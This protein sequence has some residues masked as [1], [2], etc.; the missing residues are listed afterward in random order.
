M[1]KTT[2]ILLLSSLFCRTAQASSNVWNNVSTT[3]TISYATRYMLYGY[4]NGPDLFHADIYLSLP[5]T[6]RITLWGGSWYGTQPNGN[7]N[8]IDL[9]AGVDCQLTDHLSAGVAYSIFNYLE[10]PFET[11]AEAH[12]LSGHL[13]LSAGDFTVSL[14][15]L[16][17]SEANG[18]L[19]RVTAGYYH[20]LND[21]TAVQLDAEY[22]YSFGYFTAEDGPN[23]ALLKLTIPIQLNDRFS[24]RPF[25]A[26]SIALD[27][28]DAFAEDR[29]YGGISLSMSL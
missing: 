4:D 8:E 28:I 23:H 17:D 27:R 10:V 26:H 19:T 14:R 16:Y 9:Y 13:T 2:L 3:A 11:S 7:Y 21:R 22:G 1:K 15:D 25:M 12:E 18:H 5:L 6:E 24:I 20:Q 29:T